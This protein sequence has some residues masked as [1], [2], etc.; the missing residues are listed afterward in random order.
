MNLN[1]RA[2]GWPAKELKLEY[3]TSRW[4]SVDKGTKPKMMLAH[5]TITDERKAIDF[6]GY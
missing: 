4:I 3:T 6:D 2:V 5:I 1:R